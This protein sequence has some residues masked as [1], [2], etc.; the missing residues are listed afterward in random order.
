[1]GFALTGSRAAT[2]AAHP[3][4]SPD[5]GT[6][7]RKWSHTDETSLSSRINS[8]ADHYAS[9]AQRAIHTVFTAPIPTFFMDDYTFFTDTD[10]W[11]ESNIRNFIDKLSTRSISR[12][13]G[14]GHQQR[15][16]LHLYDPTP[17]PEW[18]YTHAYS[19]YSAVV[20]LSRPLNIQ[21]ASNL[22]IYVP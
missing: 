14:A 18:S 17:P 9:H 19:A 7:A 12:H 1:M 21:T 22:Q 13:L 11:I 16:A 5:F 2:W 3:C 10:G 20:Q 8:E 4:G 15:M 6:T